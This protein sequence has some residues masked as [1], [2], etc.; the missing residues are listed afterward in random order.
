MIQYLIK[1]QSR[2]AAYVSQN[3]LHII[4]LDNHTNII[5][6]LYVGR[7]IL[8]GLIFNKITE[9]QKTVIHQHSRKVLLKSKKSL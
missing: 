7:K 5:F 3:L 8:T 4:M 2:P 1:M 9:V 6:N